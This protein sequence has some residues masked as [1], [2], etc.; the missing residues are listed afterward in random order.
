MLKRT[1]YKCGKTKSI[2]EFY[3][4]RSQ[5][6]GR[7][8]RCK[9]CD[10]KKTA[11]H[12]RESGRERRGNR[13]DRNSPKRRAKSFVNWAVRRGK[14]P[15]IS[16]RTCE[17]CG[18]QAENYHHESYK[19]EHWLMVTPLCIP[20]HKKRHAIERDECMD[21]TRAE[22]QEGR[23]NGQPQQTTKSVTR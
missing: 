21:S 10:K 13:V 18:R 14:I 2:D 9:D 12:S 15:H 17:D 19:R 3:R 7:A 20:C 16:Q 11:K 22:K 6:S 4:D 23:R 1:C 5:S 8:Y